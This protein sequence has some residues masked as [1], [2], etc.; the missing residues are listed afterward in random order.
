IYA[1]G[2]RNPFR[3]TFT[4]TGQLLVADVGE[5]TWEE[6]DN[7][8]A[9]ANYGWPLAEGPCNG[10]GVTSCATPSSFT[11][12]I[13]AYNHNGTTHDITS[14][15]VYTG[16]GSAGGSQHTVFIADQSASFVQQLT[17]TSG[18][19]SCGNATTFTAAAPGRTVQ[20]EQGSDG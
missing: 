14:V 17:C 16:V 20:L 8:T 6:V 4:P 12:P 3:L 9:G 13:Y 2:F 7:V 15:M 5:S 1:Y 10:I 19:S 11:N 18:Y